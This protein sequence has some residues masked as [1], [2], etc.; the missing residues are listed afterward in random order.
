L[1]FGS[2][3]S[4]VHSKNVFEFVDSMRFNLASLQFLLKI[5]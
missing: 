2:T 1:F 4:C 3:Y 5:C